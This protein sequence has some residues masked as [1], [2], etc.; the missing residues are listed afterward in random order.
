VL[1]E[2]FIY[3][4]ALH[5]T[6][7]CTNCCIKSDDQVKIIWINWQEHQKLGRILSKT[8]SIFLPDRML[9]LFQCPRKYLPASVRLFACFWSLLESL[10]PAISRTGCRLWHLESLAVSHSHYPRTFSSGKSK[11]KRD[12]S[13]SCKKRMDSLLLRRRPLRCR[14][15]TLLLLIQTQRHDTP[16]SRHL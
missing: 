9:A 10:W 3:S 15:A 13:C 14:S 4:Q 11:T 2:L 1:Y 5:R 6:K 12:V 16:M 7:C 8:M